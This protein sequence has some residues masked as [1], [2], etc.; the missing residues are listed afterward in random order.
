MNAPPFARP[1]LLHKNKLVVTDLNRSHPFPL[2]E[3]QLPKFLKAR[4][5]FVEDFKERAFLRM[6]NN[7]YFI[8]EVNFADFSV[9][10][11]DGIY[12]TNQ[13]EIKLMWVQF[14]PEPMS[15]GYNFQNEIRWFVPYINVGAS[16][17]DLDEEVQKFYDSVNWEHASGVERA[18]LMSNLLDSIR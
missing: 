18:V 4:L 11:P 2:P 1:D 5:Y 12:S 8:R 13:V 17:E 10:I 3:S 7:P 15:V 6:L 16:I 9:E 14:T